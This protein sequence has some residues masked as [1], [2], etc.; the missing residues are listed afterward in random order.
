MSAAG[1]ADAAFCDHCGLPVG[2]AR[3]ERTV[4]GARHRF[5]CVGC[6]IAFRLGGH[7]AGDGG[8][9]S[10]SFLARVGLGVAGSMLVM[11]VAWVPYLDPAAAT[12][13]FY[14]FAP[15]ATL[16]AATP[17][18]LVLGVPYLWNAVAGLRR[19][20][21]GA[22]LLVG[23]GIA[24]AYAASLVSLAAG[25]PDALYLDTAAGLATLVTVGRWLE[26]SAKERSAR[27]LRGLLDDAERPAARLAPGH[28]LA[29][30]GSPAQ[31]RASDL[32]V[33]DRVLVRPG[34]GVPADGVVEEG[35][36]L[37]DTAALTGEPLPR[38]LGPGDDVP[39]P[40]IPTDGPLVVR[41]T[42]VGDA[43][44]L[45]AV[46]AVLAKARAE[47]TP[48][49]RLADRV[50]AVFVPAVVAVAGFVL[51]RALASGEGTAGAF[52]HALS[53]LVIACP[54]ALGIAVPLAVT[55]ALGR[56][57]ERGILVRS[58]PALAGLPRTVAV[59]FDKT[60][61]LTQ[62]R[63]T[64]AEVVPAPGRTADE[65]LAL[66][67]A[68]EATS[69]HAI[70]RALVTA[71]RARGLAVPSASGVRVVPGCGLE[72]EVTRG[73]GR[74]EAVRVGS[75]AWVTGRAAPDGGATT[76]VVAADGREVGVLRLDD[77]L[78]DDA[79]TAVAGLRADGIAVGIL[80]GDAPGAVRAVA[81]AVGVADADAVGGCLP[82]GKVA[83]VA[84]LRARHRGPV[85]FV[86]DGLNDAPAL[87]AADLGI[88]VGSG[89]DLARETAD[90]SLLGDD[91]SRLPG[92]FR[93]ARRT[94]RAAV[95]NLVW[96]F[97]Y[98][99][100]GVGWAVVAPLPPVFAALAM[101]ASS[102]LV[103]AASA[104]LRAV[105]PEDL[106]AGAPVPAPARPGGPTGGAGPHSP[107]GPASA[108]MGA[109]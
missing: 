51:W 35:R 69:E 72:G 40:A 80:S 11:I 22:D 76:V 42:A 7:G 46:A 15:W 81:A 30:P 34:H 71:A 74:V 63:P 38:A 84:A 94:R 108:R 1:P 20:R 53:V 8:S 92:L 43:T 89:T 54:C 59:A 88:A 86:G 68:V 56:L 91:L 104:R 29:D 2:R 52:L 41:V 65:V 70:G 10:A 100:V 50:A 37:V 36:A 16:V 19:G 95:W 6:G 31:V 45:G 99:V 57:A 83:A 109:S 47:R 14:R 28:G 27:R 90:V 26:A 48:V 98:N 9:E 75:P 17:V 105:L 87:D 106:A 3:H 4:A 73:P 93:A 58:G 24:A 33:G 103:I 67:A 55:T 102:L 78:R 77:R 101:V 44:R 82:D 23:V 12:D 39:A 61:T 25:R 49:E 107:A 96:A 21:V 85:A 66:A 18:V 64:V 97:A 13:D 32:V 5:C 62:G 79:A 60:G